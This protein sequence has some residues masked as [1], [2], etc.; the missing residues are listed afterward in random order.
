MP[1]RFYAQELAQLTLR[2][3]YGWYEQR[4][5]WASF[6]L[7]YAMAQIYTSFAAPQMMNAIYVNKDKD[8]LRRRQLLGINV[9][10]P[11]YLLATRNQFSPNSTV[12]TA[13]GNMTVADSNWTYWNNKYIACTNSYTAKTTNYPE[14]N[15]LFLQKTDAI[16]YDPDPY[17]STSTAFHP[18]PGIANLAKYISG[19]LTVEPKLG[20]SFTMYLPGGSVV[21]IVLPDFRALV[22]EVYTG[23][24]TGY[25]TIQMIFSVGGK[26]SVTIMYRKSLTVDSYPPAPA[27]WPPHIQP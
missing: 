12:A 6:G 19:N 8:E 4:A 2:Q 23:P 3:K 9:C 10:D 17:M 18:V 27:V 14:I 20:S 15:Q 24:Q 7:S 25:D 1:I 22:Q 26:Q 21:G 11:D 13:C 5:R 16:T